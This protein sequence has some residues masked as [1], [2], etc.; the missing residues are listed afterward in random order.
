MI[1]KVQ[2]PLG[3]SMAV[4]RILIY[5]KRETVRFEAD[6]SKAWKDKMEGQLK[7]FFYAKLVGTIIHVEGPAPWQDW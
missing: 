5:N 6:I 3:T 1:V 7:R 4:P 2:W